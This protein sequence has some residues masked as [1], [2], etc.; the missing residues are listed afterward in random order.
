MA[1]AMVIGYDQQ[2]NPANTEFLEFV[3]NLFSRF[4]GKW[5]NIVNGYDQAAV[6]CLQL[7]TQSKLGF[8]G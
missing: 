3:Q 1:F 2:R 8:R 7:I 4:A 5:G 6:C